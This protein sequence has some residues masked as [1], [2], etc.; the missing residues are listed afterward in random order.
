M[1]AQNDIVFLPIGP[2]IIFDL[3]D[4]LSFAICGGCLDLAKMYCFKI[5]TF[6]AKC[7]DGDVV[8]QASTLPIAAIHRTADAISIF[9]AWITDSTGACG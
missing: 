7:I 3:S 9:P 6:I 5:R 2:K 8:R 4:T 1:Q